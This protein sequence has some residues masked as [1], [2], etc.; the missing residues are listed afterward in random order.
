MARPEGGRKYTVRG[1]PGPG[2]PPQRKTGRSNSGRP[3]QLFA[4]ESDEEIFSMVT[5]RRKV[6]LKTLGLTNWLA[7]MVA[8]GLAFVPLGFQ[9]YY[10][11]SRQDRTQASV[12][13]SI[14]ITFLLDAIVIG[15]MALAFHRLYKYFGYLALAAASAVL[16]ELVKLVINTILYVARPETRTTYRTPLG[17]YVAYSTTNPVTGESVTNFTGEKWKPSARDKGLFAG[18]LAMGTLF[19]SLLAVASWAGFFTP[20]D[21]PKDA[22]PS[23]INDLLAKIDEKEATAR[24]DRMRQRH[25][26]ATNKAGSAA[27]DRNNQAGMGSPPSP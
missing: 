21:T 6:T 5:P 26:R 19:M 20:P 12:L 9:L 25:S 23:N 18:L 22:T 4:G 8:S 24:L 7:I 10:F 16:L 3:S 17:S 11:L 15:V 13:V 2:G 27:G 1:P 14:V